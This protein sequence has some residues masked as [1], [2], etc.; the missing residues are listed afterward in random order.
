MSD[1][2]DRFENHHVAW[3]TLICSLGTVYTQPARWHIQQ[4]GAEGPVVA[5]DHR[6][7][8]VTRRLVRI[9]SRTHG[10]NT[11]LVRRAGCKITSFKS[12]GHCVFIKLHPTP[13][14]EE[15]RTLPHLMDT[16]EE[17][18]RDAPVAAPAI[19]EGQVVHQ[20]ASWR[21]WRPQSGQRYVVCDALR[22]GPGPRS[23]VTDSSS[24]LA[25]QMTAFRVHSDPFSL[26]SNLRLACID[27]RSLPSWSESGSVIC[28]A[29]LWIRV[30]SEYCGL[31]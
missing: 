23:S 8:R 22:T 3:F 5:Y 15:S 12:G 6:E 17:R 21:G 7:D 14:E 24:R 16:S 25:N 10:S 27:P 26:A 13:D 11:M 2:G 31:S 29:E 4:Q 20:E 28:G 18:R 19:L 9:H 1:L 30:L